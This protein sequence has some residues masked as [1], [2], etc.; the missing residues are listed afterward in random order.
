MVR[1]KLGPLDRNLQFGRTVRVLTCLVVCRTLVELR[2]ELTVIVRLVSWARS[3]LW[4]VGANIVMSRR[5][6]VVVAWNIW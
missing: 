1:V 3:V 4:L 5:F 6:T 2:H